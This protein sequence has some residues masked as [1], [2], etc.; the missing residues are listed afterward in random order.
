[1][2][3]VHQTQAQRKPV[4]SSIRFQD[5]RLPQW[6]GWNFREG[7][8]FGFVIPSKN[9][10]KAGYW[11]ERS[12]TDEKHQMFISLQLSDSRRSGAP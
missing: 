12:E 5:I 4:K 11:T 10:Q 7:Q 1:V 3:F 9:F 8:G 2:N 6:V